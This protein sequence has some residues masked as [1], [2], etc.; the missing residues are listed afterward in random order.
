MVSRFSDASTQIPDLRSMLLFSSQV[1]KRVPDFFRSRLSLANFLTGTQAT[2]PPR[3]ARGTQ[4]YSH[5]HIRFYQD[6]TSGGTACLS[7]RCPLLSVSVSFRPTDDRP[8]ETFGIYKLVATA[9]VDERHRPRGD[10]ILVFACFG[11]S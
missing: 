4:A 6:R 3:R 10:P 5:A 1:P 9:R 7:V 2:M 8:L 11:K